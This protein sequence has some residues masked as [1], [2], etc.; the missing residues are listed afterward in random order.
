MPSN[1]KPTPP[2]TPLSPLSQTLRITTLTLL[3]TLL[4]Y[5]L[6][7]LS[8]TL[9]LPLLN[10]V[11]HSLPTLLK[12][13]QPISESTKSHLSGALGLYICWGFFGWE[14]E[15]REDFPVWALDAKRWDVVL[16]W[17]LKVAAVAGGKG[18]GVLAVGCGV[19]RILVWVLYGE[20]EG[21]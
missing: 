21:V 3:V 6:H 4:L 14:L 8:S 10:L 19:V 16:L 15:R 11:S 12:P 18:V 7:H 9:V 2:H 17:G 20:W 1:R 13:Q 5:T